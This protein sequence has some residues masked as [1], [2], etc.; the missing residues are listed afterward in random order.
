MLMT[1][2]LKFHQ[3]Y[4]FDN[5]IHPP[6][7][8]ST[9]SKG[10]GHRLHPPSHTVLSSGGEDCGQRSLRWR[11]CAAH[12]GR[13]P[14]SRVCQ[15][16]SAP[17]PSY[18]LS[19]TSTAGCHVSFPVILMN[20][21]IVFLDKGSRVYVH[22]TAKNSLQPLTYSSPLDILFLNHYA[23]LCL[24]SSYLQFLLYFCVQ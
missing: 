9:P 5:R 12:A 19:Q 2:K 3:M 16:T 8:A 11:T 1:S 13:L 23:F 20:L 22:G 4:F 15:D 10:R 14:S 18:I 6:T 7:F 17:L 24:S 21:M